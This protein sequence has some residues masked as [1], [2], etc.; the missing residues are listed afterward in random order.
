ML[1]ST[2]HQQRIAQFMAKAGQE[3][4]SEPITP[5]LSM[6]EFRARLILEEA[7]ETITRGLGVTVLLNPGATTLSH[8][9]EITL[10]AN[11]PFNIIETVDGCADISVVTIGTLC[12]I[13]VKDDPILRE[14]DLA[15]LRKF[16]PGACR[17]ADGKWMKPMDWKPPALADILVEMGWDGQLKDKGPNQSARQ[18]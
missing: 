9:N 13:G 8:V 14:V 3:L 11:L 18:Y 5:T 1:M 4:P 16:G 10:K 2:Q 15:N 6:R 17:R 7:L 12:A